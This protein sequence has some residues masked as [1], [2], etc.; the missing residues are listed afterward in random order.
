TASLGD[1]FESR[2]QIAE[3]ILTLGPKLTPD[4]RDTAAAAMRSELAWAETDDL[5]LAAANAAIALLPPDPR[6]RASSILQKLKHPTGA[7]GPAATALLSALR[8]VAKGTGTRATTDTTLAWIRSAFPRANLDALPACPAPK[9][10]R[11][12]CPS[13]PTSR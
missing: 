2:R 11:L 13:L 5:A 12:A 10:A 9:H 1:I 8:T 6:V 3:A 4:Q 7:S